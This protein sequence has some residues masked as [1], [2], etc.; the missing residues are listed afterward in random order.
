MCARPAPALRRSGRRLSAAL[1]HG[2]CAHGSEAWWAHTQRP[3]GEGG[4]EWPQS[5][6]LPPPLELAEQHAEV[7][8]A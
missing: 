8:F 2:G 6:P 3:T 5:P 4:A 1:E 7:A